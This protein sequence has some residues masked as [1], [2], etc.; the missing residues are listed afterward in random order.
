M[1]ILHPYNGPARP[2]LEQL[3]DPDL[4]RRAHCPP[5]Q[6][7]HPLITHSFYTRTIIDS[8]FDGVIRVRRY[9]CQACGRTVHGKFVLNGRVTG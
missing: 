3:A 7:K 2:Y 6:A 9:L 8:A 4:H 5:C 1:Q